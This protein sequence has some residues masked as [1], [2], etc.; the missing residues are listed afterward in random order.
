MEARSGQPG[1]AGRKGSPYG[2]YRQGA[3]ANPLL[4][5]L[6]L[7]SQALHRP[8]L[9]VTDSRKTTCVLP[10]PQPMR[11]FTILPSGG[12]MDDR[13]RL[14]DEVFRAGHRLPTMSIDDYLKNEWDTG[15]VITGGGSAFLPSLHPLPPPS[16]P[17][18]HNL[19]FRLR[20]SLTR[21]CSSLA[22]SSQSLIAR[23]RKQTSLGRRSH[24]QRDPR[25]RDGAGRL[26]GGGRCSRDE[27]A[28][29]RELGRLHRGERKGSGQHDEPVRPSSPFH[30]LPVLA[31]VRLH[32]VL[33]AVG[34]VLTPCPL[35]PFA[36]QWL[37][38]PINFH[39][40]DDLS[41][42]IFS[43]PTFAWRM[44]CEQVVART[45]SKKRLGGAA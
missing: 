13:A 2:P 23:T 25:A 12:T 16:P 27:T 42:N 34:N 7:I 14:Q 28:E 19:L 35:L 32:R 24:V 3:F 10:S 9:L 31:C 8:M 30:P 33:R 15:R 44:S 37:V 21:H 22:H 5:T 11:P 38:A 6:S 45:S 20:G 29:G 39:A 26:G 41:C 18:Q 36:V 1:W 43:L 4:P 40:S 17:P